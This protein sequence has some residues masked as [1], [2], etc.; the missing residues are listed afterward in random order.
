MFRGRPRAVMA[1]RSW[2]ELS[3][4]MRR[5][6]RSGA[7]PVFF[8]RHELAEAFRNAWA[9]GRAVKVPAAA[10]MDAV[11]HGERLD[12]GRKRLHALR[13]PADEL[14]DGTVIAAA[15]EAYTLAHVPWRM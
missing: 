14:P 5:W 8:C 2:T 15:S 4:W 1:R 11:P 13:G 10:E 3:S 7:A 6:H 9:L 12:H